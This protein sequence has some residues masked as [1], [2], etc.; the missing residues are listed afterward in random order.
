MAFASAVPPSAEV[1]DRALTQ[2]ENSMI[3]KTFLPRK[4]SAPVGAQNLRDHALARGRLNRR[5]R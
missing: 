3:T 5:L 1:L 2:L 4:K